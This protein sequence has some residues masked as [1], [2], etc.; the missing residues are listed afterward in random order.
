MLPWKRKSSVEQR[1]EGGPQTHS[2][3]MK[4]G[5]SE[6]EAHGL[7]LVVAFVAVLALSM[8]LFLGS[9]AAKTALGGLGSV[10]GG[11]T[12]SAPEKQSR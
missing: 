6:F 4:L 2:F 8:A 5:G 7:G 12:V 10:L 1:P 11:A 9:G 3:K